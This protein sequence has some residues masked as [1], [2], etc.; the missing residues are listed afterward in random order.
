MT[1]EIQQATFDAAQVSTRI[2]GDDSRT[3]FVQRRMSSGRWPHRLIGT[4]RRMTEAD[5]QE[6]LDLEYQPAA[7]NPEPPASGLSP[8]T[9]HRRAS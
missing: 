8:R 4:S 5:I 3:Y 2:F 9:R 6:A 7:P 1:V